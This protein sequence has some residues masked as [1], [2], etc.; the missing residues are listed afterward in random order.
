M[1]A[2]SPEEQRE[3]IEAYATQVLGR[4]FS[5]AEVEEMQSVLYSVS[6]GKQEFHKKVTYQAF[7]A[8][9]SDPSHVD[10]VIQYINR[11]D[12]VRQAKGKVLAYRVGGGS[13]L[14]TTTEG[15]ENEEDD[16]QEGYE[17]GG[18]EGCGQKLLHLL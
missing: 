1:Q 18:E 2:N 4:E 12:R 5:A 16:L 9:I 13:D 14:R 15:G 6:F 7:S 3:F 10:L 17:D 8:A 11:K